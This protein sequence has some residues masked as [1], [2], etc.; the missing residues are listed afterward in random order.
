MK[1]KI[2]FTDAYVRDTFYQVLPLLR[3]SRIAF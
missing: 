2:K 3:G 1:E